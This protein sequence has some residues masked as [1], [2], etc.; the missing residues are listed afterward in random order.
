MKP[1]KNKKT[2]VLIGT[3]NLAFHLCSA[4]I[5]AGYTLQQI[6]GRTEKNTAAF[7]K[8]FKCGYTTDLKKIEA[9]DYYFICVSDDA[10]RRIASKFKVKKGIVM[11][12][13]GSTP[14]TALEGTGKNYGVLYPLYT[15]IK[16]DKLTFTGIPVFIEGNN[17]TA[18]KEI[19]QLAKKISTNAIKMKSADRE[20]LHLA[21][22]F[23]S[24]FSNFLFTLAGEFLKKE[25]AGK[26][27]YLLPL[28]RKT[29]SR[30]E[31]YGSF[32]TQT[33]PARRNDTKVLARH[34]KLLQKY[35]ELKKIYKLLSSGIKT[36]Y[37][38]V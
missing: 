16:N 8:K 31:N 18:E 9:A 22:V 14:V 5:K 20:K 23:A 27:E 37:S 29:L 33:G 7:A 19:K 34:K 10:I 25:S 15:F 21:A 30:L 6:A 24:N 17:P 26:F 1:E 28:I 3:G 13:S 11:H 36:R 38:S 32:E 4:L 35:P 12:C 2:F